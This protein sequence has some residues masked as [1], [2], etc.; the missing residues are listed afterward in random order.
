MVLTQAIKLAVDGIRGSFTLKNLFG[1]YGGMPSAHTT[2]TVSVTTMMAIR[3]G[4]DSGLFAISLIFTAIVIRDA[5]GLRSMV[6]KHALAI[7]KLNKVT[8]QK[9]G[10]PVLRE[11]FGHSIAEVLVGAIWG[12]LATYIIN[13]VLT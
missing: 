9:D 10:L 11:D 6:S 7:N 12:V 5:I 13:S 3:Y 8:K 2:F 4:L 1:H